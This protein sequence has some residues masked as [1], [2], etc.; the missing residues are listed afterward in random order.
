[1][2]VKVNYTDAPARQAVCKRRDAG[3]GERMVT[4]QDQQR[5]LRIEQGRQR[6]FDSA[7]S[8]IKIGDGDLHVSAIDQIKIRQIDIQVQ[9]IGRAITQQLT[10]H[11]GSKTRPAAVRDYPTIKRQADQRSIAGACRVEGPYP[12]RHVA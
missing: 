2:G 12:V 7:V 11:L 5:H 8:L 1:M 6:C 9:I 3:I 10:H 4:A